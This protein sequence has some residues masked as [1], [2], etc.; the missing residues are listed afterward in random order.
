MKEETNGYTSSF[1]E[2][3]S[4]R[5]PS[6]GT[7]YFP[8]GRPGGGAPLTMGDGKVAVQRRGLDFNRELDTSADKSRRKQAMDTYLHDL[9]KW[10]FGINFLLALWCLVFSTDSQQNLLTI[11]ERFTD[12]LLPILKTR[13]CLMLSA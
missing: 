11:N 8:F 13:L 5:N 3:S 1:S 6:R 12:N 10:W 2:P 9:R 4:S 7:E